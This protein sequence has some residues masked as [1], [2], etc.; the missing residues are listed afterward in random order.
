VKW[1]CSRAGDAACIVHIAPTFEVVIDI[2]EIMGYKN[3]RRGIWPLL[4]GPHGSCIGKSRVAHD[5]LKGS[6]SFALPKSLFV[7]P[8][9][10]V[11]K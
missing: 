11:K 5:G 8:R 6:G 4:V 9:G 1:K 3:I 10:T 2:V 7:R